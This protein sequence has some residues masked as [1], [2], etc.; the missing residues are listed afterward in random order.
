MKTGELGDELLGKEDSL[1]GTG[2]EVTVSRDSPSSAWVCSHLC[3]IETLRPGCRREGCSLRRA[4]VH[5]VL[6]PLPDKLPKRL[7]PS[8]QLVRPVPKDEEISL[9]ED[10][11]EVKSVAQG[12]HLRVL[13]LSPALGCQH[14]TEPSYFPRE[15]FIVTSSLCRRKLILAVGVQ[16]SCAWCPLPAVPCPGPCS[17]Q[18]L[19][20]ARGLQAGGVPVAWA[21][22]GSACALKAEQPRNIQGTRLLD[23]ESE[24]CLQGESAAE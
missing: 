13:S 19:D 15:S 18:K 21:V 20:M 1:H 24:N 2:Q 5:G 16:H 4:A 22:T 12:V 3:V 11:C 17:L 7:R 23:W 8:P 10:W 6:W 9:R 14:W